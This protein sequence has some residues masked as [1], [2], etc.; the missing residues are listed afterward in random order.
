MGTVETDQTGGI[1]DEAMRSSQRY[2][3]A[4]AK[5][6]LLADKPQSSQI[7]KADEDNTPRNLSSR[8]YERSV[9]LEIHEQAQNAPATSEGASGHQPGHPGHPDYHTSAEYQQHQY[10][11][12][13]S[14]SGRNRIWSDPSQQLTDAQPSGLWSHNSRQYADA[15]PSGIASSPPEPLEDVPVMPQVPASYAAQAPP[16]RLLAFVQPS[17]HRPLHVSFP[18]SAMLGHQSTNHVYS[19]PPANVSLAL[20]P[21][22]IS[23]IDGGTL[24]DYLAIAAVRHKDIH[25]M[26]EREYKR[27]E[28]EHQ[29]R[30]NEDASVFSFVNEHTKVQKVLCQEYD[31]LPNSKEQE[32][33]HRTLGTIKLTIM[34]IP[35]RVRL[36]SNWKTK[37]NAFLTLIWI[38]RAIADCN[39]MLPHAIRAQMG[40]GSE[41]VEALG[42]VY[43]MMSE[44][45]ILN[46][47]ARL[48]ETLLELGNRRE[49]CFEGLEDIVDMFQKVMRQGRV[50]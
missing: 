21:N 30:K 5:H 11:T 14:E 26:V 50:G 20:L 32:T 13:T 46:D 49:H 24:R 16:N 40:N 39:G 2:R 41:L 38:G 27:I 45:E 8:A 44:A 17:P 7:V 35:P 29:D 48:L 9:S 23:W 47:G 15:Q 25:D 34:A 43:A 19:N 37:F 12:D 22:I 31:D 33:V 36:G 18:P 6:S 28:K 3:E 4:S 42:H 1:L 10:R